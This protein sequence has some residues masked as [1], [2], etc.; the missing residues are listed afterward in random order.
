MK[1][2]QLKL[3][4]DTLM[5]KLPRVLR[6]KCTIPIW[7]KAHISRTDGG[8]LWLEDRASYKSWTT[9]G[10]DGD[11][12]QTFTREGPTGFQQLRRITSRGETHP[13]GNPTIPLHPVTVCLD[14]FGGR[15]RTTL[16]KPLK[17]SADGKRLRPRFGN[18]DHLSP[19][20]TLSHSFSE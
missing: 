4:A 7:D 18:G 15:C 11:Q 5:E 13:G 1:S 16:S 17:T 12:T 19:T 10:P 2:H 9:Y 8:G 3:W 14:C 6:E 20:Y